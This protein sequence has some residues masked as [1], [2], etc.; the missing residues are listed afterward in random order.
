M[1]RFANPEYLFLLILVPVFVLW[2]IY[3]RYRR[4]SYLASFGDKEL[5]AKLM[6]SVSSARVVFKFILFIIAFS[7]VVFAMAEP[8]IGAKLQTVKR[9][10]IEVMVA[11]DISNSMLANDV[12][13]NRLERS[14]QMIY[15]IM[16]DMN[17]DKIG[18]VVFAGKSFVQLPITSD[19]RSA[20]SFIS[21]I[22][23]DMIQQQGTSIGGAIDMCVSSFGPAG[24]NGR[25]IIVITD[26]ENHEDDAKSAAQKAWDAGI[27]VNVIGIGKP[28]GSPI[29]IDGGREFKKDKSGVTVITKLNEAM[30]QDVAKAGGGIYV[31]ADNS[32]SA[33][34]IMN[35]ELNKISSGDVASQIYSDF[36]EQFQLVLFIVVFLLLLEICVLEKKNRLFENVKLFEK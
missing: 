19:Y 32:N 6:P 1:F 17:N 3:C 36:N 16:E 7:G 35:K 29:P 18:V 24:E 2:F 13:P 25:A 27:Q 22:S 23:P 11:L 26:G 4:K 10:G 15:K 34:K 21:K 8:Q 14:K 5:I 31:R 28:E 20:K 33:I 12:A 30:A 9:K